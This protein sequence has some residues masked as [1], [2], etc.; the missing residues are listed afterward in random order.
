VAETGI[1]PMPSTA[2]KV[3]AGHCVVAVGY[4][5]TKRSFIIRNSWAPHW[6]IKGYCLISYEY[7]VSAHLASDF[8]TLRW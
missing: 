3:V 8:W 5:D 1:V 7:L 6:G 2:E 4:D